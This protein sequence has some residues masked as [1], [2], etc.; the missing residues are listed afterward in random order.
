MGG[1][2]GGSTVK[3]TSPTPRKTAA[4][5]TPA[6]PPLNHRLHAAMTTWLN[7]P[8]EAF[9]TSL[10]RS[11]MDDYEL[12]HRLRRLLPPPVEVPTPT[13]PEHRTTRLQFLA[14]AKHYGV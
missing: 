14:D 4:R 10:L 5:K 3:A 12:R 9:A 6:L 11:A 2:K 7:S 8:G 1:S 13:N